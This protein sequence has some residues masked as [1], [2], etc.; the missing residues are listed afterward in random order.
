MA[1]QM[2]VTLSDQEYAA[3]QA[4]AAKSGKQPETLLHEIMARNLQVPSP[5]RP[6]TGRELMELLYHEGELLNLPTPQV[7]TEE[8]KAER[9]RLG[10]VFADSKSLSEIVIEDRGPY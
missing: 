4:E 10:R 2:T 6:L 9:E 8:E 7:L 5:S 1:Y 3:L